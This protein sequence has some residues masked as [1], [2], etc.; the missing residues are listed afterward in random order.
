MAT[1]NEDA[2]PD[3]TQ[4]QADLAAAP[5]AAARP[6]SGKQ[7]KTGP[8][9][10]GLVAVLLTSAA[11]IFIAVEFFSGDFVRWALT[12]QAVASTG[13]RIDLASASASLIGG[14]VKLHD[15]AVAPYANTGESVL[16]AKSA[17][18]KLDLLAALGGV[19]HV[20]EMSLADG[21]INLVRDRNGRLNIDPGPPP[22]GAEPG[23]EE[24]ARDR[25]LVQEVGSIIERY[26]KYHEYYQKVHKQKAKE[27]ADKKEKLAAR[28]F[29]GKASYLPEVAELNPRFWVK[30]L[31]AENLSLR[32]LDERTQKPF[33]PELE[34]LSLVIE[35]LS[36][37][38]ALVE[39][40]FALKVN[41]R[42]KRAGTWQIDFASPSSA[43]LPD[44]IRFALEDVA[45]ADV[46]PLVA[47]SLPFDF[48]GGTFSLR[49]I[50]PPTE[51]ELG[52]AGTSAGSLQLGASEVLGALALDV[53]KLKLKAAPG[54]DSILGIPTPTFLR[55]FNYAADQVPLTLLFGVSGST[56]LPK[57]ELLNGGQLLSA[58]R[59]Q[60]AHSA[61]AELKGLQDALAAG[62]QGEL[63]HQK[64][65]L[66]EQGKALLRGKSDPKDLKQQLEQS[67][68]DQK[69]GDS[70]DSTKSQLEDQ[71]GGLF[72]K[73]AKDKKKDAGKPKQD[74]PKKDGG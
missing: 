51:S 6:A 60:V 23:P 49:S 48:E 65:A 15:L 37:N 47:R 17:V 67:L 57:L 4:A 30:K 12:S 54:R 10:T 70:L 68:K 44:E 71:L 28:S 32:T 62:L 56:S 46:A 22:D 58:L 50:K 11:L 16:T 73:K 25:D 36:S 29:P 52:A 14:S 63:E 9:R 26:R 69:L 8:V 21:T 53:S 19:V 1:M 45:V 61:S 74:D 3:A 35:N 27:Q 38:A 2:R 55:A 24:Q 5:P 66:L 72:G 34:S 33:L 41:A 7:P 59:D 42:P 20:P 13:A 64:A 40:P 39:A 43:G 31:G 18:A